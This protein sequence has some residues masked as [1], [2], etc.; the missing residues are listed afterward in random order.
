M[1]AEVEFDDHF[2]PSWIKIRVDGNNQPVLQF[3]IH[4]L[5]HVV[6][7]E[8]VLGKFD[9]TLE[10]VLIVA[11]DA[12]M[13]SY[14]TSSKART[15]KWNALLDEKFAAAHAAQPDRP[16]DEVVERSK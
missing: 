1:A 5:L 9:D 12:Y 15:R 3:V 6:L 2:P 4:E 13:Y 10:E 16:L 14:V 8:L 11:L 7:S